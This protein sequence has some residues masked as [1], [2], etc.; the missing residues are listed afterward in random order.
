MSVDFNLTAQSILAK[1]MKTGLFYVPA[2]ETDNGEICKRFVISWF[3]Y[4]YA[5][6]GVRENKPKKWRCLSVKKQKKRNSFP[7]LDAIR[8]H[9]ANDVFSSQG[10]AP[11]WPWTFFWPENNRTQYSRRIF[12]SRWGFIW[13]CLKDGHTANPL[14]MLLATPN[15]TFYRKNER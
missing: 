14:V 5:F 13:S 4:L 2:K 3:R 12:L 7:C 6:L 11:P 8:G 15:S 9:I 1:W 10:T